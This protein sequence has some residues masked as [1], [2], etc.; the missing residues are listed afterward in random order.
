MTGST[1]G[2][3]RETALEL[4]RLGAEVI[5]HGR[6]SGK[7]SA[8]AD[9]IRRETGNPSLAFLPADFSDLDQVRA[10]AA[11][12]QSRW[13]VL[14]VLINNAG[15]YMDR[16]ILT[17]AGLEVTFTVNH[18]APFLLTNLLLDLLKRSTPSRVITVSSVA[19]QRG[20]LDFDNL[21][22]ERHYEPYS[23]YAVSKL[24]NI[25]FTYE[26]AARLE[27]T[28]VTANCLH[29]GVITTKLLQKGFGSTGGS[30]EEG[31]ATSVYLASSPV[32][33]SV[34]GRYFVRRQEAV[35]SWLSRD[36]ALARRLWEVSERLCGLGVVTG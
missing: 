20:G 29:P 2:I 17:P 6:S 19:H 4:A 33:E 11:G 14:H 25:L 34:T 13:G 10:M 32:V 8:V 12:L 7:A 35:S 27:G 23:A 31:A 3:G 28:G 21:Q 36:R 1:D 18:L 22:G 16:R 26:L 9:A 15:T 5:V 30:V 24:A